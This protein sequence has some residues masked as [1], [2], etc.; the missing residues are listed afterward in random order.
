[1]ICG[2]LLAARGPKTEDGLLGLAFGGPKKNRKPASGRFFVA[3]NYQKEEF[4]Q[5]FLRM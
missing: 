4:L 2:R 5:N 3:C 1:M